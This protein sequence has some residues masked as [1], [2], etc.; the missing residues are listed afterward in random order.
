MVRSGVKGII[1]TPVD[2]RRVVP[3]VEEARRAGTTV[4]ALDTPTEPESATDALFATDNRRAGELI[5]RYAR[6]KA[7]ELGLLPK[8]AMLDLAPGISTG[9]LR[10]QGF[11]EG[12][13]IAEGDRRSPA[14]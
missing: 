7:A 13:G 10:H 6:A 5:G 1:I 11:L 4:I 9:E 8:I 12:F 14:W 2:S 3:A